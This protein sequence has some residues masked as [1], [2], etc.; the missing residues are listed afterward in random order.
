MDMHTYLKRIKFHA[1][2]LAA[3]GIDTDDSDL[4]QIM[5]NGSPI[6]Y[7][8]FITLIS[9]NSSNAAIT[10]FELFDLLL[11]QENRLEMFKSS[12]SNSNI[13]I[14]ALPQ[15]E[16]QDAVEVEAPLGVG[17]EVDFK[18][19]ENNYLFSLN[20]SMNIWTTIQKMESRSLSASSINPA[21]FLAYIS[22]A[23]SISPA[24]FSLLLLL[25]ACI[26]L[27]RLA[28]GRSAIDSCSVPELGLHRLARHDVD[29]ADDERRAAATEPQVGV[30]EGAAA[31]WGTNG[32]GI[33]PG[34]GCPH[35]VVVEVV[36]HGAG[37]GSP[38]GLLVVGLVA[39]D[40]DE[41]LQEA[42]AEAATGLMRLLLLWPCSFV[43]L[44]NVS[45]GI[46]P[47][48]VVRHRALLQPDR[49]L[50]LVKQ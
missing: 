43:L 39:A 9:A 6:E 10:F 3:A 13:S 17:K 24:W 34:D 33:A 48:L 44:L 25:E 18:D 35:A 14:Q 28:R 5:M 36:L 46:L 4:V 30:V 29:E 19:E 11:T 49:K 42:L 2:T 31:D 47:L 12:M 1:D 21:S 15:A 26:A 40:S 37:N 7:E 27:A 8:S 38:D 32:G 23:E 50:L 22:I 45:L 20:H 16:N 41:V